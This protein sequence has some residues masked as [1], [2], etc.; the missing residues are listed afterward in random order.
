MGDD[1]LPDS[2]RIA[3]ILTMG[4]LSRLELLRGKCEFWSDAVS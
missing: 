4:E 1:E 2:P 3:R